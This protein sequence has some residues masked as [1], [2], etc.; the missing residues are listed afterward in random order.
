MSVRSLSGML[1]LS[2][3][4]VWI[5]AG[6]AGV[7]GGAVVVRW[8]ALRRSPDEER[9]RAWRS[10]G[11]WWVLFVILVGILALGRVGA[12]VVTAVVSLLLLDETLRLVEGRRFLPAL[13]LAGVSL[14]VWAWLDWATVYTR[15]LPLA[16]AAIVVWEGLMRSGMLPDGLRDRPEVHHALLLAIIGPAHAFGVAALPAPTG[17]PDSEMGW[18]LLLVVLTEVNDMAQS[19]WGRAMG[20]RPLAPV[21]SPRKTW[22]G[23]LGGLATTSAAALI[24]CPALTSWGRVEPPRFELGIRAWVWSLGVGLVVGLW[25]VVG[26]LAAS[27]MKR[28]AGRKDAGTLLP[29]QGGVPDRFDSM[30]LTAPAFFALTWTIWF[31]GP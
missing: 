13:A 3:A 11:T 7:L 4:G 25:G 28:R 12:L 2:E 21:L 1:G 23:L 10:V 9:W 17:L 14:Y 5:L 30:A 27:A 6:A 31:S 29:G 24:L 16:V 18:L 22:E 26:D 8:L 15:V 20:S 19:W